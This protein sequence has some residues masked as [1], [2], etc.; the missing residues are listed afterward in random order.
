MYIYICI[1]IYIY[2]CVCV[3][4]CVCA[5]ARFWVSPSQRVC[6]CRIMTIIIAMVYFSE[7]IENNYQNNSQNNWLVKIWKKVELFVGIA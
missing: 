3:C 6:E 4:V 7:F 1:N 2:V 5:R